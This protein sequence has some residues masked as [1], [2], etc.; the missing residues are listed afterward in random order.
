[1]QDG[2]PKDWGPFAPSFDPSGVWP[3]TVHRLTCDRWVSAIKLLLYRCPSAYDQNLFLWPADLENQQRILQSK[4]EVWRHEIAA[5]VNKISVPDESLRHRLQLKLA[6]QYHSSIMLLFQPS[7]AL[8]KPD[9]EACRLCYE[10]AVARLSIYSEMYEIEQLF[11]SWRSVQ[12]IFHAGVTLIYL[13]CGLPSVQQSVSLPSVSR[14]MR[15]C[16]S[17]LSTGGEWWPSVKKAKRRLER[18]AD[19]LIEKLSSLKNLVLQSQHPQNLL[20]LDRRGSSFERDPEPMSPSF[21]LS[22]TY[23]PGGDFPNATNDGFLQNSTRPTS[24]QFTFPVVSPVRFDTANDA[25]RDRDQ[26]E[27][28]PEHENSFAGDWFFPV[29]GGDDPVDDTLWQFLQSN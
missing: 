24:H 4:L 5:V 7:Q 27:G 13:V 26:A 28:P 8:R 11:C 1:M 6:A 3:Y 15:L 10:S 9:P 22:L 14:N 17:L 21:A 18:A 16:S 2:S 23:P 19:L 29:L 20:P 25:L 12:D